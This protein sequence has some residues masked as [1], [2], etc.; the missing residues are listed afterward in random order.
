[1]R[2]GGSVIVMLQFAFGF[3]VAAHTIIWPNILHY[4]NRE[5]QTEHSVQPYTQ[6]NAN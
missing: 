6:N 4:S 3:A 1:V 2:D 5:M